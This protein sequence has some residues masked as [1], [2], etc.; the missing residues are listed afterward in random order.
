MVHAS[1]P[2]IVLYL[3]ATHDVQEPYGP[4]LPTGQPGAQA[5]I[6][7]LEIG[8]YESTGHVMQ[9]DDVLAPSASEYV[10]RPQFVHA[11]LPGVVL[12]LPAA[13]EVH[14]P[15]GPVVPAIHKKIQ[16]ATDELEIGEYESTGHVM[17]VDDVLA[18]SASEYVSTPQ[19]V[20]ASLPLLVLYL[21]ATHAAQT[22]PFAPVYPMLH[23]HATSTELEAGESESKGHTLQTDDVFA[24]STPEYFPV[25]QGTQLLDEITSE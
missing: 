5:A 9:V 22:P 3:P 12:Y 18:P 15:Y 23:V 21:P 16:A 13:H 2:P 11:A 8:E 14:E 20:H 25:P 19:P 24:P 6:D 10:W 7:E 1:G 4:V 17:Q